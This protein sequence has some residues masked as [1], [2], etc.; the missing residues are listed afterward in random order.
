MLKKNEIIQLEIDSITNE[1][2]GVGRYD[3][4]AVF[5]PFTAIGDKISCRIVKLKKTFAYGIVEDIIDRSNDRIEPDC[6]TYKK[7]GG[8]SFRHISYEAE[9][10]AK[11]SFVKPVAIVTRHSILFAKRTAN[12][13]ADFIQSVHTG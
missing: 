2:N 13:S 10:R 7:C 11:Q 9:L 3:G 1:G 12:L 6:D 8:C 5:V 4:M